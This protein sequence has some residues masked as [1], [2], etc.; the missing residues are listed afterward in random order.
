MAAVAEA[1][2]AVGGARAAL[3]PW[4]VCWGAEVSN[5]LVVP[6]PRVAVVEAPMGLE[7]DMKGG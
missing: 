5:R 2:A 4:G 3:A 1:V 6:E 7:A